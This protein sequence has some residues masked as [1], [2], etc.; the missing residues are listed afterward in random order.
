LTGTSVEG[1]YCLGRLID[2]GA[3]VHSESRII[4][5]AGD[6]A[7]PDSSA[8]AEIGENA[9]RLASGL[10]HLGIRPGHRVCTLMWNKAEHVTASLAIPA[11]GAVWHPIDAG[12]YPEQ[13]ADAVTQGNDR[14]AIVDDDLLPEFAKLLPRLKSIENVI[15]TGEPD[16][17]VLE[18]TGVGA[19][20]CADLMANH[21]SDFPW[22]DLDE[23]DAALRRDTARR[24]GHRTP[25]EYSHRAV[26]VHALAATLPEA[27]GLHADD[28]L[29]IAGMQFHSWSWGL[30][31]V[32]PLTGTS[33]V[34]PRRGASG[35]ELAAIIEQ[36]RP[37][38]AVGPVE[39]W[40]ELGAYLDE[41]PGADLES[42]TEIV[43][44]R[45]DEPPTS[46]EVGWHHAGHIAAVTSEGYVRFT[47]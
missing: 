40:D 30:P 12:I 3:A 26:F 41:R 2:H 47:R 21:S 39:V 4:T 46:A 42:L 43:T 7:A 35:A 23:A 29:L 31:Y 9:G 8:F 18:G 28:R 38:K 11:M 22:P 6:V 5:V 36:I 19:L 25:V 34:L 15:V 16:L 37:T 13:I 17:S 1:P 27:L 44:D 10:R 33:L 20:T 24:S 32:A 45:S 14:V